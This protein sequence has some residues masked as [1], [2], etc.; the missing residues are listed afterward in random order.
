MFN[1][2]LGSRQFGQS[3][4]LLITVLV[5]CFVFTDRVHYLLL[6]GDPLR[7]V[8]EESGEVRRRAERTGKP[9]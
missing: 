6:L 9:N 5:L 1:L 3:S 2:K 7:K 4:E 8:S